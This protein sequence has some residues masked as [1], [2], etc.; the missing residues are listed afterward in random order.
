MD[1]KI[2]IRKLAALHEAAIRLDHAVREAGETK[3]NE[4]APSR[5]V[6]AFFT[7]NSIYSFNWE[8]SFNERKAITWKSENAEH[9]PRED[10]QFKDYV[11][12]MDHILAPET[13]RIVSEQ[14]ASSL[15]SYGIDNAIDELKGVKVTNATKK[16]KNLAQQLPGE[17]GR[18]LKGKARDHEFFP[19]ACAVLKFV[20]EVRC[21][22]FH[23]SKTRVQLLDLAER[24]IRWARN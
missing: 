14:L 10:S 9:V 20:Y 13:A 18:L 21:N 24:A 23:G 11:K 8:A 4:F 22:L 19:T 15:E 7:F 16:L 17:F 5:F 12:Y 1:L 2:E 3:W 6:Y